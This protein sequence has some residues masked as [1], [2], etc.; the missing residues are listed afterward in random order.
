MSPREISLAVERVR[1]EFMEMPGL[2]LTL[3]QAARL[4]GLDRATCEHVI[5][6]LEHAQF[7]RRT[8]DGLLARGAGET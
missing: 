6:A 4:M 2:R 8:A 3:P 7:L 5:G 1:A